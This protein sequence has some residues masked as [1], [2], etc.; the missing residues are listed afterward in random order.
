M[1]HPQTYGIQAT[2]QLL[3]ITRND[4][5]VAVLAHGLAVEDA[6]VRESS[7][8]ALMNRRSET[9][10]K[11]LVQNWHLLQET[12][13]QLLDKNW[14]LFVP[15]VLEL[16][17]SED[18]RDN[19]N[20]I[21][22][23][24]DLNL[25]D[26]FPELIT[27]STNDTHLLCSE[28][29]TALS[30]L[31]VR[32]GKRARCGRDVPSVRMPMLQNLFQSILNYSQHRCTEIVDGWLCMSSWDDA[33]M[34]SILLDP[35]HPAYTQ[36][37]R[38][39]R[40]SHEPQVIELLVGF[41]SRRS[42]PPAILEILAERSESSIAFHMLEKYQNQL[43]EVSRHHLERMPRCEC[44]FIFTS[45]DLGHMSFAQQQT[46]AILRAANASS[47]H[48]IIQAALD[49]YR[50]DPIEGPKSAARLIRLLHG[51]SIETLAGAFGSSPSVEQQELRFL[52]EQIIPWRDSNNRNL[53]DNVN[54]IFEEVSLN[55]LL[56]QIP[57]GPS[58]LCEGIASL[59]NAL[60]LSISHDLS[61]EL[62]N[63]SPRRRS[64]AIRA[65]AYLN[66]VPEYRSSLGNMISDPREEVRI[67]VI[68][69]LA[70]DPSPEATK[71]LKLAENY[72]STITNE[73]ATIA[74]KGRVLP[75]TTTHSKSVSL[76][77][78]DSSN[79]SVSSL[80]PTTT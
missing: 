20:A 14:P 37:I 33:T 4:A 64:L 1:Q 47:P 18:S 79:A 70:Q 58:L 68:E 9:S 6:L 39:F 30:Q 77:I 45:E 40:F 69:S 60:K 22:A 80:T 35:G 53:A 65:I 19:R 7:V 3:E 76:P 8:R 31:A 13:K 48:T 10:L 75:D 44:L 50:S 73:A 57:I 38:R 25:V 78:T 27:L 66:S 34:R 2:L 63:P 29:R 61:A 74:L 43:D 51:I 49:V 28:A 46:L 71:L 11:A 72:P 36:I 62:A 52:I 23:V 41:L 26:G 55:R 15:N 56:S 32:W 67:A 24:S 21:Q 17:K 54:L 5:A 16:L 59:I 42:T 12:D